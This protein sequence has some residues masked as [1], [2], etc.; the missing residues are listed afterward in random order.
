MK[1]IRIL[2]FPIANSKGGIT[3]YALDNWKWMDKS[4]FQCDFATMSKYLDYEYEIRA[5]GSKVFYLSCYAED[6]KEKFIREFDKILD[7]GYDVVHL[8]TKQWK[9]FLVEDLCKRHHISRVIVHA[10]SSGID[11]LDP[12]KRKNEEQL[13]V[14]VKGRFNAYMATDFWACSQTAANFLYGE[15]ISK[16]KI[17]I[18]PNAIEI[19]R[20][21]YNEK[22]RSKYRREYGLKNCFVIGHVGRFVY[23]KNHEFLIDVFYEVAKQIENVK[24]VLLGEGKLLLQIK[25]KVRDLNLENKVLFL[26]KRDDIHNWYQAI[27]VFCLPSRFEG[28]PISM[29]EAQASGVPSI[30]SDCITKEVQIGNNVSLIPLTIHDWVTQILKCMDEDRQD[31]KKKLTIAGYD[32]NKQIKIIE[33]EYSRDNTLKTI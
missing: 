15:Q 23:Q 5:M 14:E 25:K 19:D 17:K 13:H 29:I 32:I 21:V 11:T 4:K 12:I 9:S 18:M 1:K 8:H 27:D 2:Q 28:L 7:G 10:H 26:G 22:V 31:N 24:L 20:F 16:E 30:G 33:E 3:H 6:D